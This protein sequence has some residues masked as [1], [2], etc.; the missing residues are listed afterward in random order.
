[1][2][3][4]KCQAIINNILGEAE[5][6]DLCA[7]LKEQKFSVMID[8]STDIGAVKTMCVVVRYY[9]AQKGQIVS[10]F[11]DLIHIHGEEN[12][13]PVAT[14]T[15]QHLFEAVIISFEENS[16]RIE[17]IIGFGSDGC[18][19]MMNNKLW[20]TNGENCQSQKEIS[21]LQY[22]LMNSG[23]SGSPHSAQSPSALRDEEV[24]IFISSPVH[25]SHQTGSLS[26]AASSSSLASAQETTD[27]PK[28][29]GATLLEYVLK[30]N[31]NNTVEEHPIDKFLHGIAPTLKNLT[32]Y[33]QNLAKTDIFNI[34]QT[35]EINMFE[36]HTE[37]QNVENDVQIIFETSTPSASTERNLQVQEELPEITHPSPFTSTSAPTSMQE[38]SAET[39]TLSESILN[40]TNN[41]NSS[42]D[43]EN[44]N[45]H[46]DDSTLA[47]YVSE[48]QA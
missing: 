44:K 34:V 21:M 9:C 42:K 24:I 18:N 5:K 15:A 13:A 27:K 25:T 41:Q 43:K 31:Q 39:E 8:E 36:R 45:V 11:W 26:P 33:Y 10:R 23:T 40:P 48:F 16:I 6:Q 30:K 35:Y 12:S 37:L 32:P 22:G 46:E 17:N 47:Q 28:S 19:T 4:T 38:E 2:K 14:A 7:A 1:M 20:M 29:A 3:R